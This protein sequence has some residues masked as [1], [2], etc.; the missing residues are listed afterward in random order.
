[1]IAPPFPPCALHAILI[2]RDLVIASMQSVTG[3][4]WV[5]FLTADL[6]L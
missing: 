6:L 4:M 3:L 5:H 2:H 1:M